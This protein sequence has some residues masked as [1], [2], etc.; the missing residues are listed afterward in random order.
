M[1]RCVF[2]SFPAPPTGICSEVSSTLSG[3]SSPSVISSIDRS[4]APTTARPLLIGIERELIWMPSCPLVC[5]SWFSHVNRQSDLHRPDH[6]AVL[7]VQVFKYIEKIFVPPAPGKL[8][9]LSGLKIY[10]LTLLKN[11]ISPSRLMIV[12]PS[13]Y[14]FP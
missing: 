6:A 10:Y 1:R 2:S 3:S 14:P 13:I 12:I 9:F 8:L 5:S 4:I 7:S 11:R